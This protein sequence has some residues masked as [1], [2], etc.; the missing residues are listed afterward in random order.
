MSN[1]LA[2]EGYDDV[3]RIGGGGFS[4][5]YK[6]TDTRHSRIVAIKVLDLDKLDDRVKRAFT[7]EC[8]TMG[9][10]SQHPHIV[11]L[12]DS[13]FAEGGVPY[14]VMP[15]YPGGSC[16]DLVKQQ[17]PMS[18]ADVL[19]TGVEMASALESAH[20]SN[21]VHRDVKPD[22]I[23]IDQYDRRV[24]GDFGIS[25]FSGVDHHSE[26]TTSGLSFTPAHASPEVLNEKD[27]GPTSD[28]YSLG[29]TLY[30]LLVGSNPFHAA[31]MGS[32][33]MKV[34]SEAP[35]PITRSD[36]PPA[37]HQLISDLLQKDP[38]DR[39]QTAA[40]VARRLQQAQAEAGLRLSEILIENEDSFPT[41]DL[42]EADPEPEIVADRTHVP[43][44]LPDLVEV[45]D[46]AS[47]L[48][49]D[50]TSSVTG[51]ARPGATAVS[52]GAPATSPQFQVDPISHKKTI[53]TGLATVAFVAVA[54]FVGWTAIQS[55]EDISEAR[56]SEPEFQ[57]TD[58]P[59]PIIQALPQTPVEITAE[60]LSPSTVRFTWEDGEVEGTTWQ[61]RRTDT[62]ASD[63]GRIDEPQIDLTEL[64]A[65][66]RPCIEVRSN[67]D[68]VWSD[69]SDPRCRS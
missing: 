39:P 9:R 44:S 54:G 6:A 12:F 40:E 64:L 14:L 69:W 8:Q 42:R 68:G 21:V 17:G 58:E 15:F 34:L 52:P 24:L 56:E 55:P 45:A 51:P 61:V 67:V 23:F 53:I 25:A 60:D 3:T 7:R 10:V 66:E 22:N 46:P 27:P 43:E 29:S 2:I 41:I 38:D 30:A 5:I 37:L 48:D 32:L 16:G 4:V 19:E 59:T 47:L 65:T 1:T 49:A 31:S 20:Q 63:L 50:R 13:G 33:I 11:T 36:V 26:T 57:T 28:L 62:E 18:V 35:E